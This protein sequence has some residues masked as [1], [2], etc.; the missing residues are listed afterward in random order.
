MNNTKNKV[1]I[2]FGKLLSNK[3]KTIE[4]KEGNI[5]NKQK[6]KEFFKEIIEK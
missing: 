6:W 3:H 1:N 2:K 5:N 4:N